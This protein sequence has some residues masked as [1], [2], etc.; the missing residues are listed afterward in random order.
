MQV[1]CEICNMSN[2]IKDLKEHVL[3]RVRVLKAYSE[4][5]KLLLLS[6]ALYKYC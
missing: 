2:Q 4:L 6:L 3:L 5:W 1:K